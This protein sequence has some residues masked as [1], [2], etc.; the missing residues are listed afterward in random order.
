MRMRGDGRNARTAMAGSWGF[1]ASV[2]VLRAYGVRV[3]WCLGGSKSAASGCGRSW[4][5]AGRLETHQLGYIRRE[6]LLGVG[7]GDDEH[8]VAQ[9]VM[10][11]DYP[12]VPILSGCSAGSP[13]RNL[14]VAAWERHTTIQ[15]CDT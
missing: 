4:W 15:H 9:A 11:G 8:S 12:R 2:G 14:H 5:A 7:P 3:A 6:F 10:T 13:W 1:F